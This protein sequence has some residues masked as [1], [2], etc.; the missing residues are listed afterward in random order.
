M[1]LFL[2]V[3]AALLPAPLLHSQSVALTFD[4]GPR[5]DRQVRMDA[6]GKNR[7]ILEALKE[8]RVSSVLFVAGRRVD[9]PEALALTR[10]WGE[11]GH[12]IANHSY[13]HG[14]FPGETA[15]LAG[16]EA[17]LLTTSGTA[18]STTRGWPGSPWAGT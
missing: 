11:A 9:S 16:F 10:A 3:L 4:D 12:R 6:A 1:R 13:A 7:A 8:A 2:A 5:L 17:D 18:R 14:Y 15:T